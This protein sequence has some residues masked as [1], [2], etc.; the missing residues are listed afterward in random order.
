MENLDNEQAHR[1]VTSANCL[2]SLCT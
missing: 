1:T 2:C